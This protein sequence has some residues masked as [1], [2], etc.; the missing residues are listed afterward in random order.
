MKNKNILIIGAGAAGIFAAIN[1]AA[2]DPNLQVT[3]LEKSTKLLSKVKVSG[4]GRCNVTNVCK[5]PGELVKHYPRSNK[6]LRQAFAS[7]GTTET[8]YWFL[9][10]GVK[11]KAEPDGRMF[12]TT[13]DSQTIIDCLLRECEKY[14][15]KIMTL[16]PVQEV[17]NDA[18]GFQVITIKGHRLTCNKLL[19]A[20]GGSNKVEGYHWLEVLGHTIVPPVPSLFTFNLQDKAITQL[21]GVSVPDAQVRIAGTKLSQKGPVL[22]THW[23]LS[24]PAVLKL[25]AWGARVLF[26]KNYEYSVLVNWLAEANEPQVREVFATFKSQHPLK[27]VMGTPPFPLPKRLWEFLTLKSGIDPETRW[28]NFSG[29]NHNR[30]IQNLICDTYS[31]R[32]KTTF[33]E[34]FVTSGGIALQEVDLQTMESRVCPGLF[35]AGEVLDI[36]GVTGGFN[37]QAA[38][39]TAWLAAQAMT[40]NHSPQTS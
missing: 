23:G 26:E 21:A 20:S 37:F 3:V 9:E 18:A 39:T 14:K 32:G 22:I 33:K 19:V 34:E 27:K 15:I 30:L 25:S 40:S 1:A 28:N 16:S 12:P 6:K 17:I 24:G 36:D 7:F 35:F 13:D 8:V 10:R 31:A 2:N 29:K 11:L 4:G 38:W 5:E